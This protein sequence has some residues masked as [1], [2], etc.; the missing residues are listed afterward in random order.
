MQYDTALRMLA[1]LLDGPMRVTAALAAART[2][3]TGKMER[4]LEM[5]LLCE[6][7]TRVGERLIS[8]N[9]AFPVYREVREL[10]AKLSGIPLSQSSKPDLVQRRAPDDF[11][12][13]GLFGSA[14]LRS[15]GERLD[16]RSTILVGI[17]AAKMGE[18][19]AA[20]LGRMFSDHDLP[21]ISRQLR[22]LQ[23]AGFLVRTGF[24]IMWFY[25]L[26]EGYEAYDELRRLLKKIAKKWPEFLGAAA[27]EFGQY[28]PLRKK[29][30]RGRK[31][32]RA[33]SR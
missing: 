27:V 28:P 21:T 10:V 19:D 14:P 31:S 9:R 23:K 7:T 1:A 22:Q 2:R 4:F 17:A 32:R 3:S 16:L 8:F 25:R 6:K 24:K 33:L 20:S 11:S 13:H 29:M 5:G 26:N 30:E 12:Y 15:T 18:I